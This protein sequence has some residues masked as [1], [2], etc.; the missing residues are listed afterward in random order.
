MYQEFIREFGSVVESIYPTAA[1]ALARQPLSN[2]ET[3]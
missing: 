3:L 1:T 2:I